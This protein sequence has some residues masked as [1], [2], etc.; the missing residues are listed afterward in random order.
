[1]LL[2]LGVRVLL[3]VLLGCYDSV[4]VSANFK[5]YE[6]SGF[7]NYYHE[8]AALANKI[9]EKTPKWAVHHQNRNCLQDRY[10]VN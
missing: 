2:W 6:L 10:I 1:V 7:D 9:F 8:R 5:F 4:Y 3:L